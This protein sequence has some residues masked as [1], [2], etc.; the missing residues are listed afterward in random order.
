VL[1][2]SSTHFDQVV[3]AYAGELYHFALWLARDRHR[4]EDVVQDALTRAWRSWSH[5]K[6]E[7]AR[8]GWLYAIV[9]NEFYRTSERSRRDASEELDDAL[10]ERLADERDFTR[11]V[12]IRQLLDRL[13]SSLAE[14]LVMQNIAGLTCEE[15]AQALGI[16]AGAA[17]T[18]VSRARSA[19]RDLVRKAEGAA[20]PRKELI[21]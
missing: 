11:G 16:S 5:V 19:L 9:R 13:P 18:R 7:G 4:A 12:E 21:P 10:L 17:A 15:I 2:R 6:D 3:R 8:R 14:P 20:A 1:G